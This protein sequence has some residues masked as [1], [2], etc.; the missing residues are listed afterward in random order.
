MKIFKN[1]VIVGLMLLVFNCSS[2]D[3]QSKENNNPSTFVLTEGMATSIG[4]PF[5]WT[6]SIDPDND[7]VIYAVY[8]NN[9]LLVEDL[10]A[11]TYVI[12]Y[13]LFLSG[14]NTILVIA[15]DGNGGFTE[16]ELV[17]NLLS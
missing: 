10:N 5:N 9:N 7:T 16:Q 6:T 11:L 4:I 2:D 15:S 13:N 17:V 8:L 12:E 3:D 14:E 1:L